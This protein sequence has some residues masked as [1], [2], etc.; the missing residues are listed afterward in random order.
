MNEYLTKKKKKSVL[1]YD[2]FHTV[3]VLINKNSSEQKQE[4]I[5]STLIIFYQSPFFTKKSIKH[6]IL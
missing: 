2:K 6:N 4:M 3:K 1:F 5:K